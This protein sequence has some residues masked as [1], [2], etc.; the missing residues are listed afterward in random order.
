MLDVGCMVENRDEVVEFR[1]TTKTI[2]SSLSLYTFTLHFSSQ[3]DLG[4][5]LIGELT[6]YT[7]L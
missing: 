3:G 7:Q 5:G 2:H 4:G 1:Q 6:V